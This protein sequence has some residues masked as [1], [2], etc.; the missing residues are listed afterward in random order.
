MTPRTTGLEALKAAAQLRQASSARR[1]TE[2]P[3][4]QCHEREYGS[5][6]AYSK[7]TRTYEDS[8]AYGIRS[9][10]SM[11]QVQIGSAAHAGDRSPPASR[12]WF[13]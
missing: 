8:P 1:Y 9:A 7:T 12:K 3:Y 13:W 5:E 11:S 4:T 10:G 2:A 6:R